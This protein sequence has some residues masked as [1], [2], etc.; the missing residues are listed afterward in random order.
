M[1]NKQEL[2]TAIL[3]DFKELLVKEF[4]V[5]YKSKRFLIEMYLSVMNL[6]N[7]IKLIERLKSEKYE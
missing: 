6:D 7:T 2:K 5:D 3:K 1:I 4:T